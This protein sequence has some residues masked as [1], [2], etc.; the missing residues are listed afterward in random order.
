MVQAAGVW[1]EGSKL[2]RR[3]MLA[4]DRPFR[5]QNTSPEKE[6]RET[7]VAGHPVTGIGA[8]TRRENS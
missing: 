4:A 2:G 8:I 3:I 6:A 1:A 7:S 5:A